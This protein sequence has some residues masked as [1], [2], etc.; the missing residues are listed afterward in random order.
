MRSSVSLG[1][2]KKKTMKLNY[3]KTQHNQTAETQPSE[4]NIKSSLKNKHYRERKKD[5]NKY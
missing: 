5:R 4:E 3:F 2:K 1:Q